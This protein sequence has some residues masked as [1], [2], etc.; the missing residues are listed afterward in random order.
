[1]VSDSRWER[2]LGI[3]AVREVDALRGAV[4]PV[5]SIYVLPGHV[6]L[7]GMKIY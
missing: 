3:N 7:N 6:T 4:K 1:M 2:S 5:M